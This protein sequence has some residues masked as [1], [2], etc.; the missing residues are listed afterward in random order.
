MFVLESSRNA[1]HRQSREVSI[2]LC[3]RIRWLEHGCQTCSSSKEEVP[4][5]ESNKMLP[6]LSEHSS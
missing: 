5:Q 4:E 3:S 6:E 2:D 1:T